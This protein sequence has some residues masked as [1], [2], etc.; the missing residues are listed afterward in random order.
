MGFNVVYFIN[1]HDRRAKQR[2]LKWLNNLEYQ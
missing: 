2:I 1:Y